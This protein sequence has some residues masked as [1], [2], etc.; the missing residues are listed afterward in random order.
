MARA[1]LLA[2]TDDGLVQLANA[3][4]VRRAQRELAAGAG[5]EVTA[6]ADGTIEA[7]FTDGTLT[8]LPTGRGIADASCTCPSSGICRHRVM[9]ALAYRAAATGAPGNAPALVEN[10]SPASLD[11]DAFEASLPPDARTELR[12]LLSARHPV[13]LDHHHPPGARLPMASVRFLVPHDLAYARCDCVRTQGC[14]HVALAIRAFR[15]A[16]GAENTV[17]GEAAAAAAEAP[18]DIAALGR[19]CDAL[20]AHLLDAGVTAGPSGHSRTLA[21]ARGR[22]EALGAVQALLALDALEEQIAAYAARSARYDERVTLGLAAELFARTR[23]A[24]ATAALGLGEPF[25]TP[26]TR[27]RLIS[28]GARLRQEG[29]DIR[30]AVILADSDTGAT[31]LIEKL[32]SPLPSEKG[33]FTGSLPRRQIASGVPLLGVARGQIL[34]SVARRRAD[35]LLALGSGAGGRTQVLPRDGGIVFTAPLATD[36]VASIIA[37]FAKRPIALLRPRQ[38]IDDVHV[39]AVEEVLGQAAVS[40]SQ[41]WEG[42]VRLPGDGGV[43]HLRREFDAAA[44]AATGVLAAALDGRWGRLRQVAG[45]VRPE[46][47]VLVCEPWSLAADRF[48]VPDLDAPEADAGI[49]LHAASEEAAGILDEAER[50]LSG[51]LHAGRRAWDGGAATLGEPL[52]ARLQAAG[53]HGMATRLAACLGPGHADAATFCAAAVWLLTLRESLG[54]AA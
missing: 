14:A 48:I 33:R 49:A 26:M 40:G 53:Y 47:G 50:F 36:D 19:A 38:R 20:I 42:A 30:A 3:G 37:G 7:R 24:D 39:F 15:A 6:L 21:T 12:R 2:L 45:P 46:G 52:R 35:G 11:L 27:S 51:A 8:R 32:F 9:L 28:L 23:A 1:D 4:L 31:M 13:R 29:T 41:Y 22:A 10:W 5:P 54:A 25:E 34:T 43:L 44:P 16:D 17:A 18:A